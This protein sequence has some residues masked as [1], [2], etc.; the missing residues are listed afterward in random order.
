MAALAG[1]SAWGASAHGRGNSVLGCCRTRAPE[2]VGPSSGRLA[3]EAAARATRVTA[4]ES[5]DC[6]G[7]LAIVIAFGFVIGQLRRH[8]ALVGGTLAC[9]GDTTTMAA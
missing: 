4:A 5:A 7:A 1:S 8:K 9:R 2:G 6:A 3:S